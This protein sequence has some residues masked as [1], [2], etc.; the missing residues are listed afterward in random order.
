MWYHRL[1]QER[2]SYITSHIPSSCETYIMEHAKELGY[3]SAA[4]PTGCNIWNNVNDMNEVI[5]NQLQSY[6]KI[7]TITILWS[8]NLN[9][10]RGEIC[11]SKRLKMTRS[12]PLRRICLDVRLRRYCLCPILRCIVE[13]SD[14]HAYDHIIISVI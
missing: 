2:V 3:E 8:E 1:R 14:T 10:F 12:L 4:N 11:F 13:K 5:Y 7:W 9:P 6:S